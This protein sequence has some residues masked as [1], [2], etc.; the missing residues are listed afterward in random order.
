M[1]T[2]LT[3]NRV[4]ECGHCGAW[5]LPPDHPDFTE[6][7]PGHGPRCLLTDDGTLS[8]CEECFAR[9]MGCLERVLLDPSCV[10]H[11]T[12]A[13]RQLLSYLLV[14]IREARDIAE[15]NGLG[16]PSSLEELQSKS[17]E[18]YLSAAALSNLES[19]CGDLDN[20]CFDGP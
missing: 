5:F 6:S 16:R 18:D 8:I 7:E 11:F 2:F 10:E 9:V 19:W 3:G 20:Q 15:A 4:V 14:D 12:A 13:E 17:V 1:T